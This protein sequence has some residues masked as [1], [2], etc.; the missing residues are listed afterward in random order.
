M[1]KPTRVASILLRC[2]LALSA[3]VAVAVIVVYVLSEARLKREYPVAVSLARPDAA[4]VGEGRRLR[5]LARVR[6]L[7]RR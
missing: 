3:C 2:L 7:P 6:R 4:L 5:A 1:Q